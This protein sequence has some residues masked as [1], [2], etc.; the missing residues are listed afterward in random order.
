MTKDFSSCRPPGLSQTQQQTAQRQPPSS[1]GQSA[2]PPVASR[3]SLS[4][5]KIPKHQTLSSPQSSGPQQPN[6]RRTD[7]TQQRSPQIHRPSTSQHPIGSHWAQ[8]C[9]SDLVHQTLPLQHQ[10]SHQPSTGQQWTSQPA[11]Q[12]QPHSST[13]PSTGPQC[14]SARRQ[15]LIRLRDEEQRRRRAV[16]NSCFHSTGFYEDIL[17]CWIPY[18]PQIHH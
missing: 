5:Y 10:S 13:Q 11:P 6:A 16:S 14:S 8:T 9:R 3:T 17:P 15:E 1:G 7:L 18:L 2:D 4:S 12:R